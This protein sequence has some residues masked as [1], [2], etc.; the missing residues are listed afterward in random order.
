MEPSLISEPADQ[1]NPHREACEECHRRKTRCV[2]DKGAC[3]NCIQFGRSCTYSPRVPLGRP[4]KRPADAKTKSSQQSSGSKTQVSPGKSNSQRVRSRKSSNQAEDIQLMPTMMETTRPEDDVVTPTDPYG[5]LSRSSSGTSGFAPSIFDVAFQDV[6][7]ANSICGP[8]VGDDHFR[9]EAQL[10]NTEI[11]MGKA[12]FDMAGTGCTPTLYSELHSPLGDDI[13]MFKLAHTTN[14]FRPQL[15]HSSST[16]DVNRHTSQP[17]PRS[18]SYNTKAQLGNFFGAPPNEGWCG[19]D[20]KQFLVNSPPPEFSDDA[21]IVLPTLLY[22]MHCHCHTLQMAVSNPPLLE[23]NYTT[24]PSQLLNSVANCLNVIQACSDKCNA[25]YGETTNDSLYSS[26]CLMTLTLLNVIKTLSILLQYKGIL[27]QIP[28]PTTSAST[29]GR[30]I[31]DG[32]N[33]SSSAVI[34]DNRF[35]S[36]LETKWQQKMDLVLTLTAIEYLLSQC[37][38]LL[39]QMLKLNATSQSGEAME[40]EINI[41]LALVLSHKSEVSGLLRV[42]KVD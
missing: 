7:S 6:S 3:Q 22:E 21:L 15:V 27:L 38:R 37:H 10:S 12:Q 39:A 2:S 31:G 33:T 18:N 17:L 35:E 32:L 11:E 34:V 25:T 26:I 5:F 42:F 19:V 23:S 20:S 30:G 41:G 1:A 13:N 24:F 4:R 28:D 29:L 36:R 8:L 16:I 40:S 9:N 14:D